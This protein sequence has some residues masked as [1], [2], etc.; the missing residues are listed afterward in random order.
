MHKFVQL[1]EYPVEPVAYFI[2]ELF[3]IL[4]IIQD[5]SL[6]IFPKYLG[7]DAVSISDVIKSWLVPAQL[8]TYL[9]LYR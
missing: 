2:S 7:S 1:A 6:E 5:P 9:N 4:E 3:V 8:A